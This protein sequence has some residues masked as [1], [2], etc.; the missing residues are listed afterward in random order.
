MEDAYLRAIFAYLSSSSW[1]DVLEEEAMALVDR[2][3]VAL[4]FLSDDE[5]SRAGVIPR[6]RL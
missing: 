6:C 2:L 1:Q 5:V 4:R 3:S